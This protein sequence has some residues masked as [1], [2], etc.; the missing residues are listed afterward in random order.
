MIHKS[1]LAECIAE[2]FDVFDYEL[3]SDEIDRIATLNA[4]VSA[5]FDHRHRAFVKF[6]A[7][8][9]CVNAQ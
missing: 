1:V 2:N 8:Y 3:S 6:I 9:G 4:G 7:E 5:L